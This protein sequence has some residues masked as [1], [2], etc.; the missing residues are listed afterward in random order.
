MLHYISANAT[1]PLS[2]QQHLCVYFPNYPALHSS[3]NSLLHSSLYIFLL[4]NPQQSNNWSASLRWS[5][6]LAQLR[7]PIL[8]PMRPIFS[9]SI[10]RVLFWF[11]LFFPCSSSSISMFLH[12][13]CCVY[14]DLKKWLWMLVYLKG[15]FTLY[16][17]IAFMPLFMF[18]FYFIFFRSFCVCSSV[19]AMVLWCIAALLYRWLGKKKNYVPKLYQNPVIDSL[20]FRFTRSA[21]KYLWNI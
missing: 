6:P 12:F 4:P 1:D 10:Y 13:L 14:W 5:A 18:L 7:E 9:P 17:S 16:S 21:I 15:F 19:T 8:F 11:F 3:T 20:R 2:S